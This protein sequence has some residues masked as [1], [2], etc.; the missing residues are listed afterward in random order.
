MR[1]KK[2]KRLRN[3]AMLYVRDI[4]KKPLGEGYNSYSY[5][6]NRVDWVPQLDNDG[7]PM[8]DGDGQPLMRPDRVPGTIFC[9]YLVRKIYKRLKRKYYDG[10]R[11]ARS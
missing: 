3:M 8:L 1:G 4:E 7:Y 9:D 11:A 10:L 5:V 6:E 2:S